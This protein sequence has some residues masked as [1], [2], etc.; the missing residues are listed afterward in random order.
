MARVHSG[1]SI[2]EEGDDIRRNPNHD[3]SRDDRTRAA[4]V[5][6]GAD[7]IAPNQ[8]GNE[9]FRDTRGIWVGTKETGS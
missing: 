4:R 7:R 9:H 1:C 5:T 3:W 8:T 6:K 2:D